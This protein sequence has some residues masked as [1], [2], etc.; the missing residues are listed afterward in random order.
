MRT[1]ARSARLRVHF[2][3]PIGKIERNADSHACKIGVTA[4]AT[5]YEHPKF[6]AIR[7]RNPAQHARSFGVPPHFD[8]ARVHFVSDDQSLTNGTPA[9]HDRVIQISL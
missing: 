8:S 1:E 6:L 2:L 4:T 9:A 7:R 5:C 3:W